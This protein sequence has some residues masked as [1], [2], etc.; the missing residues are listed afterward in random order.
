MLPTPC[1]APWDLGFSN[2]PSQTPPRNR[3]QIQHDL[4]WAQVEKTIRGPAS[5]ASLGV[6]S[7]SPG[8]VCM[9]ARGQ[10][11]WGLAAGDFLDFLAGLRK[12]RSKFELCS[13]KLLLFL[14][15]GGL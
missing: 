11:F 1:P 15:P 7:P 8:L 13:P 10:A 9:C 14:R 12:V 3:P 2:K 4:L 5:L 6:R